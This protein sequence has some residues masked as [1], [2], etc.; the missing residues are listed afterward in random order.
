MMTTA[1]IESPAATKWQIDP[2]HSHIEF[3]IRHLM[4]STVRGRFR[5]FSGTFTGDPSIPAGASVAI[6]IDA[7]SID[8]REGQRDAH[9]RSGDFFQTDR[10]PEIT[11]ASTQV[12][13]DGDDL[14][15]TGL[16]TI[17][18]VTKDVTLRVTP[19]GR[20]KDPWG[21]ERVGYS[22]TTTVNR[23]EFGLTWNQALETGGVLV[24][25][26]VKIS[27]GIQLVRQ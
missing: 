26:E 27:I 2:V 5:D 1:T 16:L 20:A 22:A 9:L 7:A 10:F 4:I 21:G 24:G 19:E 8:T 6:T 11:F 25:D 3:A 15:V 13:P 17:R 18:G 12:T 23:K 14:R